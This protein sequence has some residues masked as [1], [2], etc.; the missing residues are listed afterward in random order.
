MGAWVGF[1]A[2]ITGTE[3]LGWG[4]AARAEMG[5]EAWLELAGPVALGVRLALEAGELVVRAE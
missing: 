3:S 1:L 2:M 5:E 4:A